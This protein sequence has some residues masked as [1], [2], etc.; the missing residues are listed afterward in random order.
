MTAITV[1]AAIDAG[2]FRYGSGWSPA[3]CSNA[4]PV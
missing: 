1:E 3:I 4:R 2:Q